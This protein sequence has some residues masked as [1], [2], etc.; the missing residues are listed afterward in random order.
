MSQPKTARATLPQATISRA[1]DSL[2]KVP[3]PKAI[4]NRQD[5]WELY[6]RLA[7]RV[8][9]TVGGPV[10]RRIERHL[11]QRSWVN[12]KPAMLKNYLVTS[13]QDPVINVQSILARHHFIGEVTGDE[14]R[15]LMA[16][17]LD[18]A[19]EKNRALR[20]RQQELP[21]EYGM[22]F[23]ELKRKGKWREAFAQIVDDHDVYATKWT[24]ALHGADGP[25]VSI[26]EAACGSANDY[27][28]F[29][30]YGIA[31][32]VDYTGIDLTEANIANARSMFP[33][34][35][36]RVGDVQD[37]DAEDGSYDWA[38]AH[39]LLEHLSPSAFNRAIDELSRVSRRGV[40]ISFF[41]MR[42]EPEH[43]IQ[44]RRYYHVNDLSKD[45]IEE[46]FARY[47][48]DIQW[49]QIRPWLKETHDFGDY[50]NWRAWTMI[51]KH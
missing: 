32:L 45:R 3:L 23:A 40:L 42:D 6:S 18:W 13:Y 33:E 39:D 47:C 26:I 22:S 44:P 10:E 51:A 49:T 9:S 15:A 36:F 38:V 21:E 17:E 11:L 48:S 20:K 8:G 50:Y 25:R 41:L 19:V 7:R 1:K 30:G 43:R 37:I 46:R 31:P 34:A 5:R 35:D 16:E 28:A 14:H 2:A 12:A 4:Q 24:E 27:R 29:D